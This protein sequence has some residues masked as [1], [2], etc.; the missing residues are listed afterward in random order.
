MA[1]AAFSLHDIY[2]SVCRLVFHLEGEH[3]IVYPDHRDVDTALSREANSRSMLLDFFKFCTEHPDV[4]QDITY[5][6]APSILT[7]VV[8]DGWKIRERGGSIGRM[9]FAKPAQGEYFYLRMLLHIVKS[10]K[11]YVHLKTVPGV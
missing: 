3:Q 11:G 2:P 9:Y 1:T 7:F 6:Q 10:P 8:K 4:T 5:A